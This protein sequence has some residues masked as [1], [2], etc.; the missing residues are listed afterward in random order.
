MIPT[1]PQGIEIRPQL[2]IRSDI[3]A[4][5]FSDAHIAGHVG[6][7]LLVG[8]VL[9]TILT[10]VESM[11]LGVVVVDMRRI[12]SLL[13]T[14]LGQLVALHKRLG[15]MSWRLAVL[16]DDPI[17]RQVLAGTDLDRR[18]LVAADENE[19]KELLKRYPPISDRATW[20][21]EPPEFTESEIAE[22]KAFGTTLDHTIRLIEG[23]R[24]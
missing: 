10:V 5:G 22:I 1:M 6:D 12:D 8:D 16:V 21:D 9:D 20:P 11:P 3:L 2:Q 15:Q 23:L 7:G 24:R 13:N 4:F 18:F 14:D 17:T 19:L